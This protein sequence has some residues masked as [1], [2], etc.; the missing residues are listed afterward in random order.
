MFLLLETLAVL[1]T[2]F[3]D[4]FLNVLKFLIKMIFWQVSDLAEVD[5]SFNKV[6]KEVFFKIFFKFILQINLSHF[7]Q[8]LFL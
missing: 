5:F 2:R 4:A 6:K 7:L 1:F 3:I 8:F